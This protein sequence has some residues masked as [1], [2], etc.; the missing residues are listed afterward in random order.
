MPGTVAAVF[1]TCV[2]KV[3]VGLDDGRGVLDASD[4]EQPRTRTAVGT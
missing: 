4:V 3:E 1:R 2:A